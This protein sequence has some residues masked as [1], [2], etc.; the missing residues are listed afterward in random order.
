MN[1]ALR[2][3]TGT[4]NSRKIME[5]CRETFSQSNHNVS[6]SEMS[7]N[8]TNLEGSDI[9]GFC[10]PVYAF[11]IPR[12]C[13]KYLK[14]ID[15]FS[16]KQKVFI[17]ITAG[18]S[19]ES[20][21]AV[22]ECEKILK[23]KNCSTIYTAVIQMPINWITSPM[24]PFPPSKEDAIGII[25]RG[26]VLAKQVSFEIMNGHNQ[27]HAFNYPKRY[28][29]I[30]FYKDYWLFKYMGLPNLWRT[31][32]VYDTC[33]GCSLCLRI[34]PT[35]S[36]VFKDNKPTWTSSCEQCMRCVNFCPKEAIYQ[37]MGGDTNGRNRYHEPSF[38]PLKHCH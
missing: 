38:E 33:N 17:L 2:Y 4:G 3:F 9:L 5:V 22:L 19:D 13:R 26:I 36:I 16:A 1:I 35:M 12:I 6:I 14:S 20:G 24:P 21:F 27:Y 11:G 25:D 18:D 32:K 34:C 28:S 8:E 15:K 29:K 7:F 23:R 31:F 37:T 30:K 10:F